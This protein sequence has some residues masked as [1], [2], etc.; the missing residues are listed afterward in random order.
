KPAGGEIE[1]SGPRL[2]MIQPAASIY[3]QGVPAEASPIIVAEN[4]TKVYMAGRV[5]V[6][7]LRGVSLSVERGEF[8]SIVGPSG[9]GKSMLFYILGGLTGPT[10]GRVIIEGADFSQLSDTERTRPDLVWEMPP[11]G[12]QKWASKTD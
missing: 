12:Q 6:P 3:N 2:R 11:P 7:A 5:A 1:S 4:L 10:S 8:V 9:S